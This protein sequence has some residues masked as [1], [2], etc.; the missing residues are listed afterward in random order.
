MIVFRLFLEQGLKFHCGSWDQVFGADL[1]A[2]MG[3]PYSFASHFAPDSL[4]AALA[5]YHANFRPSLQ[6]N[7]PYTMPALN[8]IAAETDEKA[9]YLF[10][11]HQQSMT[12]LVRGLRFKQRPPITDME[13]Y[14]SQ[15]EKLVAS[16]M[17]TYSVVG[18]PE[19]V[20]KGLEK[21]INQTKANELIITAPIYDLQERMKSLEITANIMQ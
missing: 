14:W 18:S 12:N 16:H 10:T 13:S 19:T 7:S 17:L 15:Q 8:V 4:D 5:H 1:A 6:L 21:F 9:K 20:Q 3:L 11:S 2:R